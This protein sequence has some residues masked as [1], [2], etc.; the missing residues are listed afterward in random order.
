V[1]KERELNYKSRANAIEA[2]YG[3]IVPVN[4]NLY[5]SMKARLENIVRASHGAGQTKRA[6]SHTNE[7][8][9][10]LRES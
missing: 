2:G 3:A 6:P 4:K 1:S 7:L 5:Y 10:L 8:K 9:E